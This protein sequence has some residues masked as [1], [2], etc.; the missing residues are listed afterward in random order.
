MSDRDANAR[1]DAALIAR[2]LASED[3]AAFAHLMRRHQGLVRAQLR[4]LCKGDQ[5]WADDLSQECFLLA[6]RKLDQFRHD[7]RFSTWLYKIA[8]SCFLQAKRSRSEMLVTEELDVL[9]ENDPQ[10]YHPDATHNFSLTLDLQR[11]MAQLADGEREAL[12][13]CY[14]LDL[15]HEEAAQI[16]TMP[17]GTLKSHIKRGKDKLKQLLSS[18]A[19]TSHQES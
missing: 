2:V 18:W 17:L 10:A 8:Y 16:L 19:P 13:H 12:I 3:R 1:L 11:A 7:S 14:H 15:S 6:W 9:E 4:R 5:A